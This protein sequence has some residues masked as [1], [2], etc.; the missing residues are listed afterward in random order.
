MNEMKK[1]FAHAAFNVQK[2][3]IFDRNTNAMV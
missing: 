2:M 3:I 1:S